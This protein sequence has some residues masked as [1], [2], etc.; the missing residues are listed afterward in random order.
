MKPAEYM[1]SGHI[2]ETER[3]VWISALPMRLDLDSL[4]IQS[5]M[6]SK[7]RERCCVEIS[8]DSIS[9]AVTSVVVFVDTVEACHALVG[10]PGSVTIQLELRSPDVDGIGLDFRRGNSIGGI[11]D[12]RLPPVPHNANATIQPV[13]SSTLE[14]LN[15]IKTVVGTVCVSFRWTSPPRPE[16]CEVIVDNPTSTV[17]QSRVPTVHIPQESSQSVTDIPRI[18]AFMNRWTESRHSDSFD[19][20]FDSYVARVHGGGSLDVIRPTVSISQLFKSWLSRGVSFLESIRWLPGEAEQ[21]HVTG[22]S[23]LASVAISKYL[24]IELLDVSGEVVASIKSQKLSGTESVITVPVGAPAL[25]LSVLEERDISAPSS[26]SRMTSRY[27]AS[28]S[29]S[30]S[31]NRSR[32][33]P[34]VV[35]S[36]V[37]HGKKLRKRHVVVH[38][39][40]VRVNV[41]FPRHLFIDRL[42]WLREISPVTVFSLDPLIGFIHQWIIIHSVNAFPMALVTKLDGSVG[43][44]FEV[45][46]ASRLNLPSD[47]STS[48]KL[49][50]IS[51]LSL[52]EHE[53]L[54]DLQLPWLSP[55]QI[56]NFRKCGLHQ[57]ALLVSVA[58]GDEW[59]LGLV[60]RVTS[61]IEMV[62]ITI[63]DGTVNIWCT[64]SMQRR[65]WTETEFESLETVVTG[66]NVFLN[67]NRLHATNFLTCIAN[68]DPEIKSLF[69]PKDDQMLALLVD[70]LEHIR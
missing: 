33:E 68:N 35:G 28:S 29:R 30:F 26:P 63:C 22:R 31:P 56:L 19:E 37:L 40:G 16:R 65:N 27:M 49:D 6:D 17:K 59:M 60:T 39:A 18:K 14:I 34:H 24:F 43:T 62:P 54:L 2:W 15:A 50:W 47:W 48:E 11:H 66:T 46:H 52:I 38:V 45:L 64:S 5:P 58:L 32:L 41:K 8:I 70:R 7:T 10:Q 55:E 4:V 23:I 1:S 67:V 21:V 61:E 9:V 69:G 36:V 20:L 57:R 51:R 13:W 42:P 3:S 44:I 53:D 12:L 25:R